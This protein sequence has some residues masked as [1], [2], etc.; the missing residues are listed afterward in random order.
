MKA[1]VWYFSDI[2]SAITTLMSVLFLLFVSALLLFASNTQLDVNV[3]GR[4]MYVTPKTDTMLLA[5]LD[6]TNE[7]VS[8][9]ELV[10][11]CMM[12]KSTEFA[13]DGKG[14]EVK[15]ASAVLMEKLTDKPYSLVLQLPGSNVTLASRGKI[16]VDEGISS[17]AMIQGGDNSG[18]LTLT[19]IA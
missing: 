14:F 8:M 1:T 5:Y 9:K 3:L 10:S 13:L 15:G 17:V 18:K 19:T 4:M 12:T 16:A 2:V 11:Y 7:S 6:A